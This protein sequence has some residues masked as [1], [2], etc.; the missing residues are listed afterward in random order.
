LAG[1][2]RLQE[3]NS[4]TLCSTTTPFY[5]VTINANPAPSIA[6]PATVCA[7]ESGA[8]YT[9][10]ATGNNFNWT[11]NGGTITAGQ[12]TNSITVTWGSA[13]AGTVRVTETIT[14]T[15]CATTTA[16]YNVTINANPTPVISGNNSVCANQ[17]GVV[18]STAAAAGRTYNWTVV[19]GAITS[20]AGTNSITVTWGAAGAG[21]V[22][23]QEIIDATTC[24]VTTPFYNVTIN[25][26]PAP[27][28]VGPA[29]ACANE[30]GA[31]YTTG[32]TG[33]NFNWTVNG[34]TITAGQG[35]NSITVTWGSA[36]AGTV[37]VTETITATGCATTTANYNVT[38]NANP[39]PV[40][41][42]NNSVCENQTGL[43]YSTAVAAGRT[44]N[45]T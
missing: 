24:S 22:Q 29:T 27:S 16:N 30:S 1:T 7:N 40:I 10:A 38:I 4:T 33:N 42:G 36:G 6:G 43:V 8:V 18:Y 25:A 11:V 23:L 19:G 26:N 9:T 39:T 2:V 15:G 35:T 45:W 20:G 3:T 12:G 21:T 14:A 17:T 5:N 44:Y 41:S 37:R 31:V 13:G 32:A 34:G 28:I